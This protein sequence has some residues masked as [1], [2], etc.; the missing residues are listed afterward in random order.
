MAAGGA[1]YVRHLQE[2]RMQKII[3]YK[4]LAQQIGELS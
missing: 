1:D 3:D 4:P 2:I